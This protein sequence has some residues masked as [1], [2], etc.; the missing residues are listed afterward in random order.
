LILQ[1]NEAAL[2]ANETALQGNETA[3]QAKE[4]AQQNGLNTELTVTVGPS[5]R[6]F[7]SIADHIQIISPFALAI[8][9]LSMPPAVIPFTINTKSFA[10]S[11]FVFMAMVKLLFVVFGALLHWWKKI[12]SSMKGDPLDQ[13]ASHLSTFENINWFALRKWRNCPV[14]AE[15]GVSGVRYL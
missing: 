14:D 1:S 9:Y 13:K 3:R 6:I 12:N 7:L 11:I 8:A 4:A 15:I 5:E 2:Q 10:I